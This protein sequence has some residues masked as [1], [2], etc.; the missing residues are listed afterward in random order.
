MAATSEAMLFGL[1]QGLDMKTMLDVVNVSTGRN[2]ATSDKFIN[3]V[4][5][6]TFDAG[7]H[8]ALMSKDVQMYLQDAQATNTPTAIS[9]IVGQLW[10]QCDQ[11]LPGSDFSEIY[12]Y[13]R[14]QG[15]NKP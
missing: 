12:N 14:E 15:G 8:T 13:L 6:G 10:Q 11:A 3:R 7:F 1:A 2:T 4:L 5:T 9:S